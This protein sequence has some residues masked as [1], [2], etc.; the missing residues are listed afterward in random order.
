MNINNEIKIIGGKWKRRKINFL[1]KERNLR[2]TI[3][4]IKET[5]FNWLDP[6]IVNFK[7]LDCYAGSGSLSLEAL[8]RQAHSVTLLEKN[9]KIVNQL[10]KVFIDFKINNGKIIYTD[11][12]FWLK[13][14]GIPYDLIFIDAPFYKNMVEKTI[15]LL[16]KNQWLSNQSLIYVE[17]ESKLK[18]IHI[19][20]NWYVYREKHTKKIT[21]RL[22]FRKNL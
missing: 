9:Y 2:P 11:T 13:K 8:S 22:Y 12:L 19:P 16:E 5:L 6:Y 1:G 21:F 15:Y 20:S 17:C 4:R 18:K 7:C 3:S 10:K 14:K